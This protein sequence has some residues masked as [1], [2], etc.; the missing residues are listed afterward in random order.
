[1][2]NQPDEAGKTL[3]VMLAFIFVISIVSSLMLRNQAPLTQKEKIAI[4]PTCDL[5]SYQQ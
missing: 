3:I 5:I 2:N 4:C 1:M